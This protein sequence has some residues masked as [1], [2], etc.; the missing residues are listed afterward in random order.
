MMRIFRP[1]RGL[2]LAGLAGLGGLAVL[3][4]CSDAMLDAGPGKYLYQHTFGDVPP[5]APA[6][7]VR[8]LSAEARD[9]PNLGGVPPRP[10]DAPTPAQVAAELKGL[11]Q[12][13]ADNRQAAEALSGRSADLL[14]PMAVPPPPDLTPATPAPRPKDGR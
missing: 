3:A 12:A 5:A 7:P 2:R 1:F 9:Y 14:A 6:P 13:R 10:G 11:A 8:G 4:G